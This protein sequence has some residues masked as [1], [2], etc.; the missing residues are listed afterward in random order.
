MLTAAVCT[1]SLCLSHFPAL[2]PLLLL[3]P[4]QSSSVLLCNHI[5]PTNNITPT[6]A[7]DTLDWE[8]T[9][10]ARTVLSNSQSLGSSQKFQFIR[11]RGGK[12]KRL[13]GRQ[14]EGERLPLRR[15]RQKRPGD[16]YKLLSEKPGPQLPQIQPKTKAYFR[17]SSWQGLLVA[18]PGFSLCWRLKHLALESAV[19]K[20][21]SGTQDSLPITPKF[22]PTPSYSYM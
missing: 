8:N 7:W 16:Q 15:R 11:S 21:Q 1:L 20:A 9:E 13:K 14:G 6:S 10:R 5:A 22:H 2:L 18:S 19:P 4:S 12:R 3:L 17:A